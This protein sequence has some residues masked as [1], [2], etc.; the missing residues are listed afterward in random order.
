MSLA[1]APTSA[2]P[3]ADGQSPPSMNAIGLEPLLELIRQRRSV[4]GFDAGRPVPEAV[5]EKLL[6][7]AI[8]APSGY[9]LQPTHMITVTD[10][11]RRS[12]LRAAC[13]GQKSVEQAPLVVVFVG[14]GKVAANHL[15]LVIAQDMEIGGINAQYEQI[16]RKYVGIGF[17]PGPLGIGRLIKSLLF[18]LLRYFAPVP[19]L[20][21]IETR[22]WLAK[23]AA[24]CAMNFMLAAKAAGLETCPMEGFDDR[25]V[26]R[27]LGL[28]A[29]IQPILVVPVGYAP[30]DHTPPAKSRLPVDR[31]VH[32][33]KWD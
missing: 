1:N 24:L 14:D 16:L 7:A 15:D 33:E 28:P 17:S 13:M 31:L 12:A 8:W 10:S 22:Y 26:R 21:V 19:S 25:R 30:P 3:E 18:P 23:Q 6:E 20:P 29:H 2:T 9:N 5:R 11:A 4:R 32:R 27:V